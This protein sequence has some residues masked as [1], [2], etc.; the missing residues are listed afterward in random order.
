MVTP[1]LMIRRT[2]PVRFVPGKR[3]M[4]DHR[5]LQ[6]AVFSGLG[7]ARIEEPLALVHK[8][9]FGASGLSAALWQMERGEL[10]NY[11]ALR[12]A[13]RVSG[14]LHALLVAYSLAKF[15]RRLTVTRLRRWY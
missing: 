14:P 4:E 3:H 1:S 10:D 12:A 13:G 7:V 2:I 15:A 8:P 11:H 9:A 6:E 5:F